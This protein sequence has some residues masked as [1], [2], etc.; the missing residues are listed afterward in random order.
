M[1]FS[2]RLAELLNHL[3][4]PKRR[5]GTIKAICDY[6][7]L[8]RHQISSLLKNEAKYVPLA[9]LSR[10]CDYL[11]KHGFADAD[12]LP[13]ALFAVEP[14]NFWEL[15]ARRKR[16]ELCLGVR[17]D[18]AWAEGSWVVASDSL[19]LG[20]LLNGVSTLG[21]TAHYQPEPLGDTG[22]KWPGEPAEVPPPPPPHPDD[23][24]QSHVW[25]PGQ[26]PDDEVQTR[27]K[28]VYGKFEAVSGDKALLGL[29]SIKSNPLIE[30]MVAQTFDCTPFESQDS[31]DRP[32]DRTCPFYLRYRDDRLPHPD[33]CH[34][35]LEL[36]RS[37][38]SR[39][40]GIYY[41]LPDGN[42]ECCPWDDNR[43]EPAMVFYIYRE[44]QGRLEMVL[45][46]YT[47]RGTRLLAKTLETR[48][49]EFWPPTYQQ[50][51]V[52]M[53]A[54][55]IQ[56]T[57]REQAKDRNFLEMPPAATPRVIPIDEGVLARRAAG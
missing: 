13:G 30:L 4:D 43:L 35:G 2:F 49:Q 39:S 52:Q 8:D 33:S 23:L 45:G 56:Y 40:P 31:L 50:Q 27:A 7:G 57:L 29:G 48:A 22:M 34:G 26:K 38:P 16:L 1:K 11:V 44:S 37:Q 42:W 32:A 15:L 14:E 9:A 10:I 3:P 36:S 28:E 24:E 25:A 46:G 47:G 20:R 21:G 12:R 55:I 6:T 18:E 51:G 41:E 19:L 5:P 54:F 53:G 17:A